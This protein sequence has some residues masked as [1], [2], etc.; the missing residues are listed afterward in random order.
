MVRDFKKIPASLC[1]Y[2]E[3]CTCGAQGVLPDH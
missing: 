2:D 1:S 3:V